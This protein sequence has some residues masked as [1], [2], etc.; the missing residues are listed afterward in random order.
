MKLILDL[1]DLD[2]IVEYVART[3]GLDPSTARRLI[4]DVL[5]YLE[6]RPSEFV[7]RRH[8][9]LHRLG[10]TNEQ[11]YP[12]ISSELAQRRFPAPIYSARQLRRIV[13]G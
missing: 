5:S 8:A 12:R 2:D 3:G 13:Y 7:R 9:A 11:I 1:S 10:Y 4:N 6:E